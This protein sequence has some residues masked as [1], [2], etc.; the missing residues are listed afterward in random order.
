DPEE[1]A[2]GVNRWE[3]YRDGL[4]PRDLETLARAFGLHIEPPQTYTVAELRDLL[5]T[6]GPLWVGEASA[7][8]HVMVI[9]GMYGDGTHDGT[10]MRIVDP[11]PEGRGER[12]T[13]SFREF[14]RNFEA[15]ADI[16]GVH[17]QVLH[18]GGRAAGRGSR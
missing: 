5:D 17:A 16:A 3:A 11:W 1:V 7:G 9:A 8:L 13:I 6:S 12:Y 18:A 15:V 2:R 10:F 14:L 4:E